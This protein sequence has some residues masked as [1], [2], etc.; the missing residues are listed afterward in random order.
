MSTGRQDLLWAIGILLIITVVGFGSTRLL[1]IPHRAPAASMGRHLPAVP[2]ASPAA[3]SPSVPEDYTVTASGGRGT[4]AEDAA[5]G[6][7]SS[8]V[9]WGDR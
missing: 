3:S 8:L 2:S 7:T 1:L 6:P 4:V 5:P 9:L